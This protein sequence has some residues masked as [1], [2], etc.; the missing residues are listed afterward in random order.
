MKKQ[1][2]FV[3]L[4]FL[5]L[6]ANYLLAQQ[7]D[8]KSVA[9]TVYNSNLGVVKDL[10][11]I[12]IK[13]GTSQIAVTDVAQFIDPTSVH[14]SLNGEVIEQNYQYDLVSL[15]KI[16]QKYIDKEIQLIGENS[17]LIEGRLLSAFAGQIVLEKKEGGLLMLPNLSKYRFSVGAL[18][19]GLIT[20]PTLLWTVNSPA[21]GKQD[22]EISYQTSGMNWHAEYVAVLNSDDTELD[23]NSWVSVENK[24]GTTY[25]NAVLKL[26]AGDINLVKEQPMYD[27]RVQEMMVKSEG[28]SQPQFQ[29]KEFFEYHIYNLQRPTTLANNET[30]QISLFESPGVKAVKKYFY[31]SGQYGYYGNPSQTGKVSVVVEFE[32]KEENNMGVPMPKGKVR[33]YKSDGSTLEFVGE[34]LID[35]T[36]RNENVRLK[37]G[38]AFDV[39]VEDVQ[40]E[41]KKI[42][43]R[44]WEQA[45]EVKFKNRKKEDITVEVERFLGVNWEILNS[46]L[47]YEKKDAQ[48]IIFKVPVPEDGETVLKYRV[49][50][51]Y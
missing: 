20:K 10:R 36:P 14:I 15:D 49:R 7:A 48:N 24:S 41:N 39:V 34:D 33:M 51:R 47:A 30:K 28:I 46:S 27:Y 43:D 32:N 3:S 12:N 23:L 40:T 1:S 29:E 19:E 35:H 21:T 11:T 16:L 42:T 13:S 37:I 44:V 8:Q 2:V 17:E 50:Y 5:A 18:P 38:E 25:K 9:V 31:K 4:L 26:V 45:Y 6:S 22:V